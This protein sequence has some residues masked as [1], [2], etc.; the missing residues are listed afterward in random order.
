MRTIATWIAGIARSV[1][2]IRHPVL[3]FKRVFLCEPFFQV[4]AKELLQCV[5]NLRCQKVFVFF[6]GTVSQIFDSS[7]FGVWFFEYIWY[8]EI[9]KRSK[10]LLFYTAPPGW[11]RWEVNQ[12]IVHVIP[13]ISRASSF[14]GLRDRLSSNM[15]FSIIKRRCSGSPT[16]DLRSCCKPT[17]VTVRFRA[18]RSTTE[19]I[20]FA[21]I[22]A[23][24][25]YI[26]GDPF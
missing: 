25:H 3:S 1:Q 6:C 12:K 16:Q 7:K 17:P 8:F 13:E 11:M 23:V 14:I 26:R 9:H 18:H 10:L 20:P 21:L 2:S 15:F 19:V 4:K 24:W 5:W 22:I